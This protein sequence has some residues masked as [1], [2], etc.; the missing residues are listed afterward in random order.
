MN[1]VSGTHTGTASLDISGNA[2]VIINGNILS[3]VQGY[4][5]NGWIKTDGV[6][7]TDYAWVTYNAGTN[8]TILAIPEPATLCILAIGALSLIRRKR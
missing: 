5:D 6:P 7:W 1:A 8:K 3:T 4:I 2:K